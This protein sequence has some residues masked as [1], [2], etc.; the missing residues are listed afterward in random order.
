MDEIDKKLY[1]IQTD[2]EK[3]FI[4]KG[5]ILLQQGEKSSYFYQVISGCLRTYVI[6]SAGKECVINF[7]IENWVV[8]DLGSFI[9]NDEAIFNIDALEDTEVILFDRRIYEALKEAD[10]EALYVEIERS[11]NHLIANNKRFIQLL[12]YSAEERYHAFLKTY[13]NLLQRISQKHIA[14]YLGVTPEFL[15][16]LRKKIA[17]QSLSK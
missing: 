4:K 16:R 17:L 14:S 5:T 2:F 10:K 7:G 3:R 6:N 12:S 13:P 11:Y 15:S 8:G 9:Y 1:Q